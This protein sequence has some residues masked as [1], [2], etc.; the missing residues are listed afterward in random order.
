MNKEALI[1]CITLINKIE[2]DIILYKKGIISDL[3]KEILFEQTEDLSFLIDEINNYILPKLY[4]I[5]ETIEK[6][7]KINKSKSDYG[8]YIVKNWQHESTL[9]LELMK[10]YKL[11]F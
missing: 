3:F 6:G 2:R 9:G 10:F 7:K 1:E 5:K 8:D 4:Y 11:L